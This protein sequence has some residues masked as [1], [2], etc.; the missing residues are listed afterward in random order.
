MKKR[1]DVLD[2]SVICVDEGIEYGKVRELI[3]DPESGKVVY[4]IIDDGEWYLGAKYLEFQN[5][6]GIGRDAVTTQSVDN[7]KKIK[8]D[9]EVLELVK[10]GIKIIGAKVYSQSGEYI[11][12]IDEY[13][14]DEE[15]GAIIKCQLKGTSGDNMIACSSIVTYGK[16]VLVVEDNTKKNIISS[17][18][19]RI[20]PFKPKQFDNNG[21]SE[22]PVDQTK[23]FSDT[24]NISANIF[25][26]RQKRFLLG[27]RVT[28]TIMGK[29]GEEIAKEG[30]IIDQDI[31]EKI[32]EE[33]K[34]IELTMKSK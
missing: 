31:I 16:S 30:Q 23:G 12:L 3:I 19:S 14:I 5:I 22:K 6:L 34:L 10:K 15:D 32:T 29:D 1:S 26:E 7:I 17:D 8:E 33:G 24:T 2:L 21:D 27:K 25:V 9:D 18:D 13:Y 20:E 4:L 28:E 11:G